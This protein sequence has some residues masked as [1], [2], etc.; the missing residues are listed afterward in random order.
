MSIGELRQHFSR[1]RKV[2]HCICQVG[3]LDDQSLFT[4]EVMVM[5]EVLVAGTISEDV[6]VDMVMKL[7]PRIHLLF[8]PQA[9]PRLVPYM[10]FIC[11]EI[12]LFAHQDGAFTNSFPISINF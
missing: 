3:D 2:M 10:L 6:L 12:H 5:N 11:N 7:K 8:P 1:K 9:W 4:L